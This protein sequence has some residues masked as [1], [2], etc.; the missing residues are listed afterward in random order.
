MAQITDP[1]VLQT[2]EGPESG[3]QITDP[4]ILALLNEGEPQERSFFEKLA[5]GFGSV[6]RGV[7]HAGVGVAGAIPDITNLITD[8]TKSATGSTGGPFGRMPGGSEDIKNLVSQGA[9]AVGLPGELYKPQSEIEKYIAAGSE[10]AASMINPFA[11]AAGVRALLNAAV[12]PGTATLGATMGLGGEAGRHMLPD[13]PAA[14]LMGQLLPLLL[15]A[16]PALKKPQT[17]KVVQEHLR[18]LG[19]SGL[20]AADARRKAASTA[21]GIPNTLAQGAEGETILSG[22]ERELSTTPEGAGIRAIKGAQLPAATDQV[23]RMISRLSPQDV[24][25]TNIPPEMLAAGNMAAR[26]GPA[27]AVTQ[28]TAPLYEAAKGDYIPSVQ[29]I[30]QGLL[31]Q[32]VEKNI[33]GTKTGDVLTKGMRDVIDL[34]E[35][36]ANGVPVLN[37]DRLKR[38]AALAAEKGRMPTASPEAALNAPGNEAVAAEINKAT[39]AASPALKAGQVV[40]TA[41]EDWLKRPAERKSVV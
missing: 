4:A 17:V 31:G 29:S 41:G 22:I 34:Q 7:L 3:G 39:T 15:A 28:A 37:L 9:Q 26:A 12:R 21:T 8:L 24:K 5:G 16:Y 20:A 1:A 36:Y 32:G 14:P 27:A 38:E 10:G 33:L 11:K 30:V 25:S 19:P 40:H 13:N 35:L 2:L 23:E 18:E 6:G